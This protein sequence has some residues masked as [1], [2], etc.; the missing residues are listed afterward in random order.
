[1]H[2]KQFSLGYVWFSRSNKKKKNDFLIFDFII[3]NTKE[4]SIQ[5]KN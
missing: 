5:L 3:G 2:F 4:S 1:M